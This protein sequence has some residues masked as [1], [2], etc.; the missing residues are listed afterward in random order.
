MPY[1]WSLEFSND[2]L[3]RLLT[4]YNKPRPTTPSFIMMIA[5]NTESRPS[6]KTMC[7][8][9]YLSSR[10]APYPKAEKIDCQRRPLLRVFVTSNASLKMLKPHYN[11]PRPATPSFIMMIATNTGS[12]PSN[13][14]AILQQA[15]K[16]R[17]KKCVLLQNPC[18]TLYGRQ[19]TFKDF[20]MMWW[21]GQPHSVQQNSKCIHYSDLLSKA[22]ASNQESKR[23]GWT[24]AAIMLCKLNKSL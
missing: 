23:E 13:Q 21:K 9:K 12:R 16:E 20:Y 19:I 22:I 1:L 11:R 17:V 3:E 6:N 10:I 24:D 4:Q 7:H 2:P 18:S 8:P 15:L 5:T 14:L